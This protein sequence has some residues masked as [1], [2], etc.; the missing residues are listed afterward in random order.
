MSL[1]NVKCPNCGASIQLDN[2]RTEGF[3]S[4]CGSKVKIEEAQKLTI[5]GTVKVDSSDELAN[6][7]QIARR[8]KDSDN[9][10]NAEKYYD[11]ILIKDPNSW[12]A[13]FYVVY[14]K[15]MSCKLGEISSEA[16]NIANCLKPV[17]QLVGDNLDG[18]EEKDKAIS[19]IS[20]K[21]LDIASMFFT[22]AKNHY[23]QFSTVQ[24]Q[25]NQSA[26]DL[27]LSGQIAYKLGDCLFDKFGDKYKDIII[28]A[29]SLGVDLMSESSSV[30]LS[31]SENILQPQKE[32]A[33]SYINKIKELDPQA[34]TPVINSG[35]MVIIAI[36]MSPFVAFAGYLISLFI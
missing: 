6:L 8:A 26:N 32:L 28:K 23:S 27:Y 9:S 17:I 24:G 7:Y 35:C 14:F 30:Y 13:S 34:T 1:V 33:E 22:A 19:E 5:Q 18:D 10:E 21:T 29:W 15:A 4:Y 16:Q 12:E 3:C 11:M 20:T 31:A 25:A 36:V 2:D